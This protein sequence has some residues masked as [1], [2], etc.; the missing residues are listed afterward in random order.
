M[1]ILLLTLL[2]AGDGAYHRVMGFVCTSVQS[3]TV[4]F[5]KSKS[6]SSLWLQASALPLAAIN[7]LAGVV[8]AMRCPDTAEETG[9]P[10]P[11]RRTHRAR[12]GAAGVCR[13]TPHASPRLSAGVSSSLA[14]GGQLPIT[15][16]STGS[17]LSQQPKLS[18]SPHTRWTHDSC[19]C[20]CCC[21]AENAGVIMRRNLSEEI[22]HSHGSAR[23]F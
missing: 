8:G 10:K 13:T 4:E 11:M 15:T 14:C 3:W 5:T 16:S 1:K 21:C 19:C 2:R 23:V 22:T 9:V 7:W 12:A 17:T 6:I 18:P 20:C